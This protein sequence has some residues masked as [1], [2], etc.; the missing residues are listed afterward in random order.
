LKKRKWIG[1]EKTMSFQFTV[2]EN[3]GRRNLSLA[4]RGAVLCGY[5][6]RDQAAVR[7]HVA[8]LEAQG[9]EPPPSVPMFY[10]KPFWGLSLDGAIH[11]QGKETSGEI[12]FV[13]IVQDQLMY[14][15]LG[16][17]HTDRSL[18]KIDI[19][20]SKQ[21]CP[22]VISGRLWR[23]EE[24]KDHWD[25]IEFRSWT[26]EGGR[27]RIYQ[28]STLASI[29][30]PDTLV[31]LVRRRVRESIEGIAMF[32]GTSSLLTEGFVFADRF[33]GELKDPVLGRR[34]ELAYDIHTLDWFIG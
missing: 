20:K 23:Y 21:I 6:G 14:V 17:D 28:E 34:I 25:R 16:S 3:A 22:S 2:E 33:E 10:P 31:D 29:L 32:S 30:R 15:G 11:V 19:L 12:E 7:K 9:I 27:R 13:L 8:E 1:S 26:R 5:T 4:L 24:V 18:E